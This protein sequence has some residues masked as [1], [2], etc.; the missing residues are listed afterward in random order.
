MNSNTT[1]ILAAMAVFAMAFA[2]CAVAVDLDAAAADKDIIV[3]VDGVIEFAEGESAAMF[4]PGVATVTTA[5]DDAAVDALS[6]VKYDQYL[7]YIKPALKTIGGDTY[8]V[9]ALDEFDLTDAA[10]KNIL[11]ATTAYDKDTG[12][13]LQTMIVFDMDLADDYV[14]A[15][16][17][18]DEA[19]ATACVI[20]AVF[21]VVPEGYVAADTVPAVWYTQEELDEA[22]AVVPEGY[23]S[24][25]A[26][27]AEADIAVAEAI[28]DY[29]AANPAK[30]EAD[31]F[32]IP[33]DVL[34]YLVIVLSALIIVLVAFD[35]YKF[36]PFKNIKLKKKVQKV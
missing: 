28:K 20:A 6:A 4:A 15:A 19:K 13:G 34:P 24:L 21:A 33:A 14:I 27:K 31:L 25:E 30:A 2:G 16:A 10:F 17:N 12:T 35:I 22:L 3:T 9:F 26:A 1:K 18:A 29:K 11:D 32:G 7:E 8:A 23:I 36:K 5:L